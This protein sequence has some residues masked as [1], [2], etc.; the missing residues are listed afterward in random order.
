MSF[1]GSLCA[2]VWVHCTRQYL[3][4][5]TRADRGL[6]GDLVGT[7]GGLAAASIQTRVALLALHLCCQN[8][9]RYPNACISSILLAIRDHSAVKACR[10]ALSECLLARYV[11]PPLTEH[12]YAQWMPGGARYLVIVITGWQTFIN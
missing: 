9:A 12:L 8:V 6:I 7:L 4:T 10:C 1:H 2:E 11:P 5:C 3:A